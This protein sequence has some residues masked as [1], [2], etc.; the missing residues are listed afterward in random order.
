MAQVVAIVVAPSSA[1]ILLWKTSTGV[2]PDPIPAAVPTTGV[3][4]VYRA[5]GPTD[6]VPILITN[7]DA[8]NPVY[9]GGSG[10]TGPTNG[11]KLAAG[12][13]LTRN[14][15]GERFRV[16]RWERQRSQRIGAGR[17]AEV[18]VPIGGEVVGPG[19]SS[20]AGGGGGGFPLTKASGQLANDY[21]FTGSLATFL[22]TSSL[23]A[24]VWDVTFS[25]TIES[26]GRKMTGTSWLTFRHSDRD[27]RGPNV[28]LVRGQRHR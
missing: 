11:T 19:I 12:A 23:A 25:G 8:T 10:V 26:G 9:L 15:V 17:Q 14:V 16:R 7:E 6:P 13:S 1:Q 4:S 18:V 28:G 2:A 3:T 22:T 20:G 21:N 5:S 24:G 27:V